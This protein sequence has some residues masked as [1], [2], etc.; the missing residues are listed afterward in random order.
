MIGIITDGDLRR[1]LERE[2]NL[3]LLT[4]DDIMN[5]NPVVIARDCLAVK[6][7][8]IMKEK[9]L[10]CLPVVENNQV[11]GMIRLQ[12]IVRGGIVA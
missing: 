3:Y 8:Q 12:D 5:W 4:V 7:L 2:V 10:S 11:I 6:A 1:Q 9:N